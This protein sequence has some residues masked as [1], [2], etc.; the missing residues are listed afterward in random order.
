MFLGAVL[1]GLGVFL[2]RT[3][4]NLNA[5]RLYWTDYVGFF[6]MLGGAILFLCA[7][8]RYIWLNLP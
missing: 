8:G 3:T 7:A 1:V 4:P 2:L 6:M 5:M